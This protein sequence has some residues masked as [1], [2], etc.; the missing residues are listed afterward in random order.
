[1]KKLEVI[2]WAMASEGSFSIQK[3]RNSLQ[4]KISINNTDEDYIDKFK[5]L[6]GFGSSG[7]HVWNRDTNWKPIHHWYISSFKDCLTFCEPI[8]DYMPIKRRQV[9]LMIMFC[10]RGVNRISQGLPIDDYDWNIY[11]NLKS[12]NRRGKQ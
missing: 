3:V 7:V 6:V 11:D 2:A 12:L 5:E 8:L 4:P 1:M 10:K 9:E